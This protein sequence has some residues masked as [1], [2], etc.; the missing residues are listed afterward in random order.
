MSKDMS[1]DEFERMLVARG[2][3]KEDAAAERQEQEHGVM[4]DCDGDMWL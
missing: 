1:W 2:W 4:G 3:S